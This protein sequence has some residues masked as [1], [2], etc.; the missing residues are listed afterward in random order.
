[1]QRPN[2]RYTQCMYVHTFIIYFR[3][4]VLVPCSGGSGEPHFP[5]CP[6]DYRCVTHNTTNI[7]YCLQSCYLENGGCP[8]E[9]VCYYERKDVD[10]NLLLMEPCFK[11]ACTDVPGRLSRAHLLKFAMYLT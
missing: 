10:C 3:G 2:Y 5:P 11:T 9:Q 1:M 7:R 6:E 4:V 8:P